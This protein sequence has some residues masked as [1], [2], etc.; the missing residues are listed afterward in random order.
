MI[1]MGKNQ[2]ENEE[3]IKY[4]LP[5][6]VWFHVND[7][8]SAHVY[9]RLKPGETM[10]DIPEQALLDCS[11]LVK[12][13]SISGCKM[14][15]VSVVYTRWKNLKKTSDMVAGQV[16]YHRPQNVRKI[17]A[18]KDNAIVNDLNRTKE[19]R[20]PNLQKEQQDREKEIIREKKE[21]KRAEDK[22]KRLAEEE[23]RK[24]KEELSYDRIMD[25]GNMTSNADVKATADNTAAEEF[26]DDFF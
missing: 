13:N 2:N 14:K 17:M 21:K 22:A 23:A 6:D 5:E 15:E 25:V 9:I 11:T 12:A 24:R 18:Y 4:G 26:E 19:E 7:L 16:S 20:F 1:Y 10:D 8:S 3:L